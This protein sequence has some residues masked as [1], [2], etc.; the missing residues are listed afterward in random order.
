MPYHITEMSIADYDDVLN[1][2][3]GQQ[4]IGLNE[5]DSRERIALYLGR[6]PGMSF[7]IRDGGQVI[8]AVL[9]GHDGRRGYLHHLAVAPAHR[10]RGVGRLLVDRCIE[11]LR[12]EGIQKCN[13]FLF[14]TNEDGQQFWNAVG[15]RER[16]D[17][18][19]LQRTRGLE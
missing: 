2:W 4:G 16:S 13:I 11:R 7:V 10:K 15:Y 5:S 6:N 19:I 17:L 1:F 3:R 14:A 12:A 9:C 18:K 8:A